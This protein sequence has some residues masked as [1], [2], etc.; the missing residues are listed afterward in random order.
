MSVENKIVP[1]PKDFSDPSGESLTW[2][3]EGIREVGRLL[4]C[5]NLDSKYYFILV[6]KFIKIRNGLHEKTH[7]RDP[8]KLVPL[9]IYLYFINKGIFI[10]KEKLLQYSHISRKHFEAFISQILRFKETYQRIQNSEM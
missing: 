6:V 5:L 9:V 1:I 8:M 3:S 7:Y 2:I 4:E 10:D